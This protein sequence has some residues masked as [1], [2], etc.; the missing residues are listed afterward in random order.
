MNAA[1]KVS[2]TVSGG[3]ITEI[4]IV[5]H[6]ESSGISDPAIQQMPEKIIE[7]QSSKVDA[8]SNATI[9]S[10]A[11]KQAVENALQ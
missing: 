6:Q 1:V 9:T 2:V 11:I 7:A 8:I 4:N 5:E 3:Q 10:N